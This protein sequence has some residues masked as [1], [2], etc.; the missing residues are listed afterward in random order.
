MSQDD[1]KNG[2]SV[3]MILGINALSYQMPPDLSVSVSVAQCNQFFQGSAFS[4]QSTGT[5]IW[6]TGSCYVDPS[7]CWLILDVLNDTSIAAD[8]NA[9]WF[10]PDMTACNLIN[11]WTISSRSGVIIEQIS[12]ANVLALVRTHYEQNATAAA[13]N[14]LAGALPINPTKSYW[15]TGTTKRFAIPLVLIS[16]WFSSLK[17]LIPSA[18]ASGLKF[19]VLFES[20]S[21]ALCT[22][23]TSSNSPS[24]S[25]T[26]ARML[27]SNTTLSD[28]VLRSLNSAAANTGL[29]IIGSTYFSQVGARSDSVLNI[30]VSKSVSRA[31]S[32]VYMER[33]AIPG[34]V[35]DYA[36]S[37]I[38]SSAI[39][40]ANTYI[41]EFQ[42]RVGSL[43][44]P[45]S[46]IRL[47]GTG[48]LNG[49]GIDTSAVDLFLGTMQSFG[50]PN[51]MTTFSRFLTDSAAFGIDLE[52]SNVTEL[53]GIPLSNSRMLSINASWNAI[54]TG[55]TRKF[56]IFLKHAILVRVF[57]NSI[58]V[59]I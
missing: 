4:P 45:Q 28:V 5:C 7:A 12:N 53:A 48:V 55:G 36:V 15:P 50:N 1:E 23:S 49:T 20:A 3:N 18:L 26:G 9:I 47:T 39:S 16:P 8:S 41:T 2:T 56:N 21:M 42:A 57:A 27:T 37:R 34:S 13:S 44:Y 51:Q 32:A 17:T 30:D 43:Y 59:E 54:P 38:D 33:D 6:N 31:L 24:Y 19:E 25:I 10:G 40:T 58:S 29:E 22:C 46:S 35:V 14:S 11:R 52:R